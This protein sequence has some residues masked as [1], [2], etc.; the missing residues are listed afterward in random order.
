MRI[1]SAVLILVISISCSNEEQNAKAAPTKNPTTGVSATLDSTLIES[2]TESTGPKWVEVNDEEL[3]L[4]STTRYSAIIKRKMHSW[5][6]Y[7]QAQNSE[8]DLNQFENIRTYYL[9]PYLIEPSD[10]FTAKHTDLY[11]DLLVWN[12]D[13]SKAIDYLSYRYVLSKDST[14]NRTYGIDVDTRLCLIDFEAGTT[15]VL[16]FVGTLGEYEDAIWLSDTSILVA[17]TGENEDFT[18]SPYYK[19]IDLNR[20]AVFVYEDAN[21]VGQDDIREYVLS[22][23]QSK[24]ITED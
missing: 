12:N 17:M 7:H 15:T 14:G 10:E 16:E 21:Y 1:L 6:A 19:V 4:P 8:F 2:T 9:R 24:G 23:L 20:Y 13:S 3:I 11:R 22:Q 5:L 18:Y